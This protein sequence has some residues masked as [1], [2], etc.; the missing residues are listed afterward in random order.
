METQSLKAD[1]IK[2]IITTNGL[3]VIV[4]SED[5]EELN[6]NKWYGHKRG[7]SSFYAQRTT[8][9]SKPRRSITIMMHRQILKLSDKSVLVD[10]INHEG[11][12]NR[13]CNLRLAT[14]GQ[15]QSNRGSRKGSSSKYKGVRPQFNRWIST[16]S[17]NYKK[18][19]LGCFKT[20]EEAAIVYDE[21]AIKYYGEF[22]M[23]NIPTPPNKL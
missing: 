16:I 11:L 12:D 8:H 1:H 4:D 5:F 2:E 18:I 21:A 14:S 20:E 9:L 22:A 6:K 3:V 19:Y 13:R 15:N 17:V 23:L 7:N 10:H